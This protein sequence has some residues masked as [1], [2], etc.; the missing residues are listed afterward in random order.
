[1][2]DEQ[3]IPKKV[4]L[5]DVN[6]DYVA[7]YFDDELKQYYHHPQLSSIFGWLG[8]ECERH[9][10]PERFHEGGPPSSLAKFKE[11]LAILRAEELDAQIAAKRQEVANL[12]VERSKLGQRTYR[13]NPR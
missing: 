6:G 13:S 4:T 2:A 12:E 9:D 7:V 11:E 1:M 10:L 8:I 5:Y 3:K